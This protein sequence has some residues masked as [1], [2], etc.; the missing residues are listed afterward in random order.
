MLLGAPRVY[1][2]NLR[3]KELMNE[4]LDLFSRYYG[5]GEYMRQKLKVCVFV[6]CSKFKIPTVA[7]WVTFT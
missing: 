3:V 4:Y 2:Q 5:R 1:I 6:D 7:N